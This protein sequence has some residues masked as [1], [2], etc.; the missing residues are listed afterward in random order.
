MNRLLVIKD[1]L[2]IRKEGLTVYMILG[3]RLRD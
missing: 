3:R 1:S 2:D